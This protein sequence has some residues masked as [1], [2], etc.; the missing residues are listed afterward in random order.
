[1]AIRG[2][3]VTIGCRSEEKMNT[4]ITAIN[5]KIQ[6]L[7]SQGKVNGQILDLE[8]FDSVRK[9]KGLEIRLSLPYILILYSAVE[10]KC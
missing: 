5:A 2:A 7:K 3:H 1:M 6:E 4:A 8:S 9:G 10:I